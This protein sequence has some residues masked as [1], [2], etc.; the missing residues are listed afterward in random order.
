MVMQI[1]LL[2]LL[3]AQAVSSYL[4]TVTLHA[5]V[6]NSAVRFVATAA[7]SDTVKLTVYSSVAVLAVRGS[8]WGIAAAVAGAAVGNA[9][10]H[11]TRKAAEPAV[12]GAA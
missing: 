6:A 12:R 2:V 1:D 7:L 8:W 9:V 3:A 4:S 10:A 5:A 11:R